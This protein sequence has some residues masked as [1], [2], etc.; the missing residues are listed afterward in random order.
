MSPMFAKVLP[1][2]SDIADNGFTEINADSRIDQVVKIHPS[3]NVQSRFS[4][5]EHFFFHRLASRDWS[6]STD[7]QVASPDSIVAERSARI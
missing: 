5:N 7:S 2:F 6:S 4:E 3:L 1:K